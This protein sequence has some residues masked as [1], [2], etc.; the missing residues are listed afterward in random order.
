MAALIGHTAL[1]N[2]VMQDLSTA[3]SETQIQLMQQQLK[4][5][6]VQGALGLSS[7]LAYRNAIGAPTSEVS[8]LASILVDFNAIYTTHLRSE[9]EQIMDALDEAFSTASEHDLRLVVSHIKCAGRGNWHKSAEVI[10]KLEHA[11][12][13]QHIACDCYP[14][15][16]SS[17]SLDL[18]QVTDQTDIFITWSGSAPDMAG[19][20]LKDIAQQWQT[21][22][23]DAAERLQ[24]AG[25]IYHCMH[26]DD[27][28]RFLS[29]DKTMVGSDGI[30]TDP[31]PHPRLW[32]TFPRVLGRYARE[33][34]IFSLA[35]AIHRMTGLPAAQFQLPNRGQLKPGFFADVVMFDPDKIKDCATF[36]E[37]TMPAQGIEAV[38]VNGTLSYQPKH[39]A[40][41]D[42]VGRAG[43]M[44][45]RTNDLT[46]EVQ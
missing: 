35:T 34:K 40:P 44:L 42:V 15:T 41:S 16:A 12:R 45:K 13:S 2:N 8:A 39:H 6:L 25:A 11:S 31:H 33:Q 10:G 20:T 28:T 1:R 30:P 24:P 37:P 17:S 14:Y 22:L 36:T 7:G 38:W 27:V 4:Q 26:E 32:G 43:M 23:L 9:A 18:K 46:G 3:A 19:Q 29:Y 5:A 21:S